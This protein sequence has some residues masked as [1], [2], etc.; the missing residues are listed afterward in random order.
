MQIQTSQILFY[1]IFCLFF[2][3]HGNIPRAQASLAEEDSR[4]WL[5]PSHDNY[6]TKKWILSESS[7]PWQWW[8]VREKKHCKATHKATQKTYLKPIAQVLVQILKY[9]WEINL[10]ICT[11]HHYSGWNVFKNAFFYCYLVILLQEGG[12]SFCTEQCKP[13]I[14][15]VHINRQFDISS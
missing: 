7:S 11:V 1:F 13:N 2:R 8:Y 12:G 4:S 15:T 5:G 9:E 10:W 3:F 6:T 14:F